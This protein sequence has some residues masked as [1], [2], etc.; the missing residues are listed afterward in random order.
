MTIAHVN[1]AAIGGV[2]PDDGLRLCAD[3]RC[4]KMGF[5]RVDLGVPGHGGTVV[6]AEDPGGGRR[7]VLLRA[8]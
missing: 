8:G 5:P 3:V 4:A 2:W 6:G 1:G 7:A